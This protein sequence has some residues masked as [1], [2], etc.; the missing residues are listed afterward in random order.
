MRFYKGLI[1]AILGCGQVFATNLKAMDFGVRAD[2]KTDDGPAILKMIEAARERNGKA[3]R[4]IFPKDKVIYVATGKD[5]YL[6]PL[7]HTRNVT[8]DGGGSTFLLAPPI[9]MI[10]LKFAHKPVLRDFNVEYTVS[11]FIET[12]IEAIGENGKYVDVKVLEQGE[13]KN[14]GGPTK[15][16]GE[17]W[18]GGFVWCENGEHPKAARHYAVKGVEVL[19]ED[20]ARIFIDGDSIP[21][22][23]RDN[24]QPGVTRFSVP[25]PGVAH[26]YGPGPMFK[27][28]DAVNARLKNIAV[29]DAPWFTYSVYRC[30]GTCKFLNVDVVPKPGTDRWMA[31]CRDAFHVTGNR[32]KLIFDGCDTAGIGDDDYNFCIL[33]SVIQDV[34][35]PTQI[36]IQ[37]KFPIQYNPMRVGETLMVMDN[38]NSV[39]GSAKIARYVE[40]PLKNGTPIVP[41]GHC[42]QVNIALEAPIQGLEKGL[43]VWSKEASNPDTTLKNCT[44]TFS[45]RM[46]T[47]LKIDRCK[48]VCY[49]V[50]YGMSPRENNVEGPGPDFMCITNSEFHIGRGAGYHANCAGAGPF[51]RH[52]LQRVYIKN[53]TFR[54]PLDIVKARSIT[55]LNNQFHGDVNVRQYETLNMSGNTRDGKPFALE[56]RKNRISVPKDTNRY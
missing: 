24:I 42:P 7:Q 55:L 6:F 25:R 56:A 50:S 47:S 15:Q 11:M 8:V 20:E 21:R 49:N 22:N 51:A 48:F 5:R 17:Q 54:G 34:L 26:R 44:A 4:L 37:Q 13:T 9:R 32:A 31:G 10:D 3:V 2:G 35:S 29:W 19:S 41:G 38:E 40:K 18:F 52:R 30:E 39:V 27:I 33:S 36:V 28:H 1:M 53:C 23:M 14:L 45:I 43:N 16:D 46:Q 12:I